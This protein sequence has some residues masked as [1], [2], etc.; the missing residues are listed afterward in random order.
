QEVLSKTDDPIMPL[1]EQEFYQLRLDDSDP[2]LQPG[3]VVKQWH[4]QWS[5]IDQQVMWD[6]PESEWWSTIEKAKE[7]Y[8]TRRQA[9]AELGFVYSDMDF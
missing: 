2:T 7:R 5:E 9:L 6:S 3:Y 4:G 1:S 8:D